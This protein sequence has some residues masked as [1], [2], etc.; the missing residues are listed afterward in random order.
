MHVLIIGAAGMVGQKLTSS[1]LAQ[2][3][4]GGHKVT[5]L[6]LVDVITPTVP[7]S[8]SIEIHAQQLDLSDE[9]ATTNLVQ[10]L[11]DVIIHLAAIVSGEAEKDLD[12]GYR[13]NLDG[14]RYLF[15]AIRSLHNSNGYCPKVLFSS[16]IAVYGTPFPPSIGDEFLTSPLSSYGTQKAMSELLLNDYSRRGIFDGLSMRLPTVCVRPGKPNA[17]ASSFFSNIIREPLA[18]KSANLP[19]SRDV[20]HW[21]ISPR[22]VVEFFHHACDLDLTK[23]GPRRA[24]NMPGLSVTVQEQLDALVRA[25]GSEIMKLITE[26]PDPVITSIVST[27]P[28]TFDA[29]R[30]LDLGFVA[31]ESFDDIIRVHIEDEL[32]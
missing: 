5:T 12:K 17:A 4:L 10:K 15:E 32:S 6:D 16:S 11:P 14:T 27:W 29:K 31:D 21:H 30:A 18:G 19:V 28:E 20:R 7:A 25:A 24:L 23:V 2:G 9:E 1:I 22:R 3:A 13:I 26:E 8:S